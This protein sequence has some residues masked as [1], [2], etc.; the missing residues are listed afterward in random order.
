VD[1]T[2]ARHARSFWRRF[3]SQRLILRRLSLL[4]L[5][6]LRLCLLGLIL[7]R[8]RLYRPSLVLVEVGLGLGADCARN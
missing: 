2:D 1:E 5:G 6:L 7:S 4:R 3:S 8:V